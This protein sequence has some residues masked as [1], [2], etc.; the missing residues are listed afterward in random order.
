MSETPGKANPVAAVAA[1]GADTRGRR[2]TDAMPPAPPPAPPRTL[3][4]RLFAAAG[5]AVAAAALAFGVP[6]FLQSGPWCDLTLYQM[7]ARNVLDGGVLY[8]DVF[9]TNLPGF[10]W[11]LALIQATF[12]ESLVA[13][14]V[15][16]LAIVAAIAAVLTRQVGDAGGGPATRAWFV[17]GVA[18]YYP[19]TL[20][21]NHAQR[22]V[23]ML[24]PA[25]AAFRL[26]QAGVAPFA[27]GLLWGVAVWVK[28]HVV[29]P[30][31][32]VWAASARYR[33][34]GRT[35]GTAPLL[36]A[37]GSL[38]VAGV[39]AIVAG[40]AWPDFVEVFTRWNPEYT[41]GTLAELPTRLLLTFQYFAPWSLMHVVTVPMAVR[42]LVRGRRPD[43]TARPRALLAALY[44]SWMLQALLIQRAL[45]YVH[46]P[47]TLLGL[48]V[49]AAYRVP[50][51]LAGGLTLAAQAA[52][53]CAGL[54]GVTWVMDYFPAETPRVASPEAWA[55]W[56]HCFG[57]GSP[58]LRDRLEHYPVH[59]FATWTDLAAVEGYLRSVEPP[60]RDGE[61]LA[62]HDSPHA[63]FLSLRLK[64]A[65]RYLHFGTA[66]AIR[67]QQPRVAEEVRRSAPRYAVSDLMRMTRKKGVAA[68]PDARG[69]PNG[70]P[71]WL[72]LSLRGSFP[73]DQPVAFRSGRYVVHRVTRPIGDVDVPAW[74]RL[75]DL[76]PG[77][78]S[79]R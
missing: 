56:P 24:L 74:H 41:A 4:D 35:L 20:E 1:G 79:G 16:D 54:G 43:P 66:T 64:P 47:E 17:A 29:V 53:V 48:A 51:G 7:A 33:P 34:P 31:F 45:D 71:A 46:V 65:T 59:C 77:D 57:P 9:D 62:F 36:A 14:R 38:G 70:L 8:R 37:G 58:A 12:G 72:P 63:L 23:W 2:Y 22:D 60:L 25:L 39:A 28:P 13:V 76:G 49:A 15:I 75:D 68:A 78:E 73:W 5:V 26:R 50:V 6:L 21:F 44:L 30:A 32:A 61:L 27:E 67:S 55:A 10:V 40:G 42:Q 52:A 18:L 3:S 11:A 19:F 69:D